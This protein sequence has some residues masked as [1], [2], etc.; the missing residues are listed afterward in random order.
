MRKRIETTFSEITAFFPRHIHA[1][2][3]QGFIL[4]VVLFI[5]AYTFDRALFIAT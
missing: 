1:V 3:P 4:K 5:F 2:T